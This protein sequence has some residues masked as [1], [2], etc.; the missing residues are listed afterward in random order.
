MKKVLLFLVILFIGQNTFAQVNDIYVNDGVVLS[1]NQWHFDNY[2]VI[3]ANDGNYLV[4]SPN[5]YNYQYLP[6]F[7]P[8]TFEHR[9]NERVYSFKPYVFN[10]CLG[11]YIDCPAHD[12]FCYPN[13][14]LVTLS[15]VPVF[16]NFYYAVRH[17]RHINLRNWHWRRPGYYYKPHPYH[18]PHN[19]YRP[20]YQHHPNGNVSRPPQQHH[21]NG[22]VSRP[23]QQHRPNG[24]VS[25]PPQQHRPNGNVSRP[26]QQH[27]P[28]GNVSRP[29]E[30]RN[31]SHRSTPPQSHRRDNSSG[32]SSH[33]SQHRR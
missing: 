27:R 8:R 6:A 16:H 15:Y 5:G 24:N 17:L 13:G 7:V 19:H 2:S 10:G 29:A 22:N 11:W 23:P 25:R 32:R 21:P 30:N 20:P 18:P 28:N 3:E 9:Y 1:G 14:T 31:S 4:V 33:G 26:P 12:Y